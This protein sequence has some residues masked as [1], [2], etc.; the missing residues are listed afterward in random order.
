LSLWDSLTAWYDL[1][2]ADSYPMQ[3]EKKLIEKGYNYDV[4]NAWVSWNTSAQLLE[5]LDL[6][7]SDPKTLPDIAILVI[8]WNDWLRWTDIKEISKNIEAIIKKLKEKN[9]KIVLWWMK[10]PP[11]LWENY[12]NDFYNQYKKIAK[13]TDVYLIDF[14]LEWV[15]GKSSLGIGDWIH[16]NKKWYEIVS[17]NVF[18]FLLNNNL[19]KND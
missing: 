1:D 9:I 17:Q 3:L 2:L 16:P 5:R 18:E 10:I 8:W 4:I 15:A 13:E 6:Y 19:I 11:N 14:F 7:L 12:T